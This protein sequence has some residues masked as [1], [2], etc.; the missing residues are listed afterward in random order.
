MEIFDDYFQTACLAH[1][2]PVLLHL[3]MLLKRPLSDVPN[4]SFIDITRLVVF[5]RRPLPSATNEEMVEIVIDFQLNMLALPQA[6]LPLRE[7]VFQRGLVVSCALQD[8][9]WP[10]L[11]SAGLDGREVGEIAPV[12]C[13]HAEGQTWNEAWPG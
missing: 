4:N 2:S 13:A 1:H 9:C 11:A 5:S 12:S 7:I 8:E 3:R 6:G 10:S